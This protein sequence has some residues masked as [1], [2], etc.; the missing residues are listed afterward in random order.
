MK[1]DRNIHK[2]MRISEKLVKVIEDFPGD[3][4]NDKV[5]N[6]L[7]FYLCQ[8]EEYRKEIKRLDAE[9]E[10]RQQLLE[11]F[12]KEFLKYKDLLRL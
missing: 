10:K 9:I 11:N 5:N 2:T 4:F 7:E 3:S 12:S 1:I 8:D 6:L